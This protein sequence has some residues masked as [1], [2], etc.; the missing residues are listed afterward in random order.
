MG[1]GE[2]AGGEGETLWNVQRAEKCSG[3]WRQR[4]P[5]ESVFSIFFFKVG[6]I[7]A[8]L[9]AVNDPRDHSGAN[10]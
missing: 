2:E 8:H 4:G 1:E 7:T 3:H 5:R 10:Q 9:D 6:T